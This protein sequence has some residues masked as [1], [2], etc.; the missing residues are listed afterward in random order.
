MLIN[1]QQ[2]IIANRY[3]SEKKRHV[4]III[5]SFIS[6]YLKYLVNVHDKSSSHTTVHSCSL[7]ILRVSLYQSI[8]RKKKKRYPFISVWLTLLIVVKKCMTPFK[9]NIND[10]G[11]EKKK[12]F[13]K[14]MHWSSTPTRRIIP[15]R[16]VRSLIENKIVLF[17]LYLCTTDSH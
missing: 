15:S 3:A 10:N 12:C 5:T 14:N 17:I 6:T 13:I 7:V 8:A 1:I 11:I 16:V 4:W 9:R 2:Y